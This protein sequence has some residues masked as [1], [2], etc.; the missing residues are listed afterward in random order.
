MSFDQGL[1]LA[2]LGI[3]IV[4]FVSGRWRHD[5][6]AGAT[7]LACVLAGLVD[8]DAAFSGF[9]HPAVVT[10]AGV[11]IISRALQLSGAVD[12]MARRLIPAGAG[13]ALTVA[14]LT[15]VA[16]VLSGFMN[17]VGALAL[18]MPIAIQT[19]GR[20]GLP[21]GRLLMPLAFGSIL[22]G[23]T[24]LI[25][26]PTN[27]IVSGFRAEV[28]E[29]A[30]RM[31][32]FAPVGVGVALAGVAFIVLIGWRL[33][34]A[35]ERATVEGFDTGRYFTEVRIGE[36]SKSA[37]KTLSDID[38]ALENN[39]AQ[40]IGLI[41]N[42][43]RITAPMPYRRLRAGDI[44][45]I[46]TDP[47]ALASV[48]SALDLEL[49]EA[50]SHSDEDAEQAER[51]SRKAPAED[52]AD[53]DEQGQGKTSSRDDER[54]EIALVELA[55]L[56]GSALGGRSA[57]QLD[58]RNR[59]GLNMLALSRA[60][61][62]SISRLK[63]TLIRP[64]DVLLMQGPMPAVAGFAADFGCVP[65]ADRALRI[66]DP[67][68]AALSVATLV[69]AVA[70]AAFG[71]LPA[72]VSFAAGALAVVVLDLVPLRKV[73]DAVDWPVIVLL[74]ALMPVAGAMASTG[75]AGLLADVLL[76]TVAQG[77]A[78]VAV[79]LILVVTMTLSDFMNNAATAAVMCPVALGTATQLGVGADPFLMAVA[80]G[81]SCAFLTPIGHQNNTLI[82]GPG[83]FRF[84]DYLRLGLPVEL[85]VIA[86]A[87]PLLLWAWP[88]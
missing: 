77:N 16:A 42:E 68:K 24:T 61:Q 4:L 54:G 21:P 59:Y 62:R 14:G 38:K 45:V 39:D 36:K 3:A 2:I 29:G 34:T 65:L 27:L 43:T 64:G 72:A 82:M 25:G 66:P 80:I 87:I 41:R 84:G 5:L 47:G 86:T 75:A 26:T 53:E 1:I 20:L 67:R 17:N 58:L 32:D 52:K 76:N 6:V 15:V 37:G 56:P 79:G 8:A 71:W 83:G 49:E 48:L 69:T 22:G 88:L 57:T 13:P 74:A 30:F 31:F 33:V 9:G 28:G 44:L 85:L 78:V 18:L 23:M 19:A 46:E 40:I 81:G 50:D 11:L 60:G 51:K 73:Y 10:V 63:T 35:R 70:A 55:V 12:A 7:L